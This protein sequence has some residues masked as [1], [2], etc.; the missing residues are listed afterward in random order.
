MSV[1]E[2]AFQNEI[3]RALDAA[4][5]ALLEQIAR[6]GVSS[7]YLEPAIRRELDAARRQVTWVMRARSESLEEIA[8]EAARDNIDLVRAARPDT[9]VF[10][11]A[12]VASAQERKTILENLVQ[13]VTNFI[14]NLEISL[15]SELWRLRAEH[16]TLDAVVDRLFTGNIS[17]TG[18]A[19]VWRNAQNAMAAE[20]QRD[21]WTAGSG[22][23]N[24]IYT[25]GQGGQQWKKQVIAAIDERTTDCCL[26]VH[27][28]VQPLNAPFMLTG[29]PRFADMMQHPP[30]HWYCRTAE[31]LWIEEFEEQGTTTVAMRAAASAEIEAREKTGTRPEIHPA[32]ATSRRS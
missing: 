25:A 5:A 28:Q 11:E 8:S 30:F 10:E 1:F 2:L 16:E 27:G 26:R 6:E 18:R 14:G 17:A 4:R 15:M 32:H 23:T 3:K 31:A 20:T 12:R 22:L 29:T 7:V 13:N 19:S 24:A 21:L 9:P